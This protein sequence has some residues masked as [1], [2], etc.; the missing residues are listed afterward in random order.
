LTPLF[1]ILALAFKLFYFKQE[2]VFSAH[3]PANFA[4]RHPFAFESHDPASMG[5]LLIPGDIIMYAFMAGDG[6]GCWE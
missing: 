3:G 5:K 2:A 1:G 6:H 4:N